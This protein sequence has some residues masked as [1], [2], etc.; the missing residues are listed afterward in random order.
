MKRNGRAWNNGKLDLSP[1]KMKRKR[2]N[3]R[4]T[5]GA[6]CENIFALIPP[7]FAPI[8]GE[9]HWVVTHNHPG[10]H[11]VGAVLLKPELAIGKLE[12]ELAACDEGTSVS[13]D[14]VY[15]AIS[16]Q[17][18]ALFDDELDGRIQQMLCAFVEALQ[19]RSVAPNAL[20]LPGRGPTSGLRDAF[21][22]Q[23]AGARYEMVV[24]GDADECFALA[25]PVAELQ[26]IDDWQFHLLY[27][28]SGRN[29]DGCIFIEAVSGFAVHRVS[30]SDTYWYTTLY[31][32]AARRFHAVL[33]TGDFI[34]GRW[35]LEVDAIGDGN[36]RMRWALMDTGLSE[37]G[38]RIIIENGFEARVANMLRFIASSARHYTE[39]GEI[40]RLPARRK[41]K[42]ALSLLSAAVAQHVRRG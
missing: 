42:L 35:S 29:E 32:S 30:R 41:A 23:S 5:V 39:T 13:L 6:P 20:L 27:S 8:H 3:Y 34:I 36:S 7:L 16:T 26:W 21:E 25:C 24:R 14:F 33:L 11:C 31:D 9:T 37:E 17:G 19:G 22:P 4:A 18:N 38:N 12:I 15:T 2:G 1:V 28:D 10:A 40:L